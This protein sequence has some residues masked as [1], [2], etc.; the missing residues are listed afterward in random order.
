MW[1]EFGLYPQQEVEEAQLLP[2]DGISRKVFTFDPAT[3]T[4]CEAHQRLELL[5]MNRSGFTGRSIEGKIFACRWD[6]A[7]GYEKRH[8]T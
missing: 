6:E 8:D 7:T 5:S 1:K 4:T 3:H 2:G